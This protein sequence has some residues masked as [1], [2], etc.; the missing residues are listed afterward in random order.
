[1]KKIIFF[2]IL[3]LCLLSIIHLISSIYTL[4][5]KQDVLISA[6]KQLQQEKK[7]HQQL[8]SQ[9]KTVTASGF[10]EEE[11]RNK[12]F[13]DKPGEREVIIAQDV[14]TP[15][16]ISRTTHDTRPHWQQWWSLFFH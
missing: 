9:L 12:L 1:M 6:E 8:E 16:Q 14:L 15:T 13:M 4:W 10:V 11:A 3:G 7:D 5:H 2:I